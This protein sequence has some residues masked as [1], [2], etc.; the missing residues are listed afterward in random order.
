MG[1]FTYITIIFLTIFA[2][3]C[4][5]VSPDDIIEHPARFKGKVV[6]ISGTLK[7]QR[8]IPPFLKIGKI[9]N[10]STGS[11]VYYI[12]PTTEKFYSKR[13][14]ENVGVLSNKS[15]KNLRFYIPVLQEKFKLSQT[16]P[17]LIQDILSYNDVYK[18]SRDTVFI[19][20]TV[21]DVRRKEMG[22]KLLTVRDWSGY[23][24]I[25]VSDHLGDFHRDKLYVVGVLDVFEGELVLR[26]LAIT[27]DIVHVRGLPAYVYENKSLLVKG[28]L[29]DVIKISSG[30]CY[31]LSDKEDI[32]KSIIVRSRHRY[33]KDMIGHEII[34]VVKP[35][36]MY[37]NDVL[38]E[39]NNTIPIVAKK[40]WNRKLS[41]ACKPYIRIRS[42]LVI[43]KILRKILKSSELSLYYGE[44]EIG[45][46]VKDERSP[47]KEML[48]E[49]KYDREF[50]Y[51][52]GENTALKLRTF[53]IGVKVSID[54]VN[55]FGRYCD[56]SDTFNVNTR[57]SIPDFS[58]ASWE[59]QH[60]FQNIG[61]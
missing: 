4:N 36:L 48:F 7:D 16:Q 31:F 50:K 58:K 21:K 34:M 35:S 41:K 3:A 47:Q 28:I 14:E 12:F 60:I 9:F 40:G 13:F 33:S 49:L 1:K 20:C 52:W 22:V 43:G 53:G 19:E 55:M 57:V 46:L 29:S 8:T 11:F 15:L 61:K 25:L 39:I 42:D 44:R 32:S 5:R 37:L 10:D 38:D 30:Y 26:A 54:T 23:I 56:G 24:T 27:K 51:V 17:T 2:V 6:K 59:L 45:T 18:Y